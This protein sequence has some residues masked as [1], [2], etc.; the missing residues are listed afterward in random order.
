MYFFAS[1]YFACVSNLV[2]KYFINYGL[3]TIISFDSQFYLA[4]SFLSSPDNMLLSTNSI[5]YSRV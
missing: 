1:F 5:P 3:S 4:G 2:D